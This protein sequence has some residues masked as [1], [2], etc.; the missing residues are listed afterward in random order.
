MYPWL[1]CAAVL[2]GGAVL[3]GVRRLRH[4]LVLIDV[5]GP[6]M[7]PTLRHGDAVL[8]HRVGPHRLS[9]GD[10]VVLERADLDGHWRLPPGTGAGTDLDTRN[11]IIKRAV[12]VA[13]DVVPATLARTL[14][15]PPDS[16]VPSGKMLVLGDNPRWSTD[17]REWGFLPLDRVLG[18]V[19]RRVSPRPGATSARRGTT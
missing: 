1:I 5:H 8:V 10:V 2:A 18:V 9:A 6:S 11:W 19:R 12:A 3:L 16:R 7:E 4:G 17:S 13:G 14:G 15:L